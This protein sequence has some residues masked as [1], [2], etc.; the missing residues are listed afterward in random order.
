M[1]KWKSIK[2]YIRQISAIIEKD[3]ALN[4]RVKINFFTKLLNPMIQLLVLVFIFGIIFNIK[5]GFSMG[6]WNAANY[7]LFLLIAY[8]LQFSKSILGKYDSLFTSEKYWKTL[9]AIMVAPINRFTLLTGVLISE[10]ILTSIPFFI[11]ITIAY[12]LF[13]IPLLFLFLTLLIFLS[14]YIIFAGMGLIVGVFQISN[15]KLIHISQLA[16]RFIFLFSCTNYPKEIFPEIIQDIVVLNPFYYLFDLLRLTWYLGINY[17]DAISYITPTHIIM[18]LV[19]TII[20]PVISIYFF[21]R[22]YKKYG[23]TGY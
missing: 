6:Y 11:L 10:F 23:I 5:E 13:P 7:I 22:V 3:L 14:I 2:R 21:D 1:K 16:L 12:I 9:S 8:S 20:S 19:L 4:L 18:L 15:E 17:D